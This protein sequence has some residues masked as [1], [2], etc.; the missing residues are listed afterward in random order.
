MRLGPPGGLGRRGKGMQAPK[1]ELK[2]CVLE[3]RLSSY[4]EGRE[5]EGMTQ[6]DKRFLLGT[7]QQILELELPF[8]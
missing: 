6:Q 4:L 2:K 3:E 5:G 1:I 8:L 7:T